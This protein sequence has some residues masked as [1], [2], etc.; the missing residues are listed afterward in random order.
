MLTKDPL[1]AD[2][3]ANNYRKA[4]VT[5]RQRAMLDFAVKVS[6]NAEAIEDADYAALAAAGFSEEAAWDIASVAA[7]FAMSNRLANAMALRPN[8]E[9]YAMGRAP[10]T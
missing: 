8:P 3:L 4:D 7:F 2:Q 1:V 10:R 9:F 5:P 6:R